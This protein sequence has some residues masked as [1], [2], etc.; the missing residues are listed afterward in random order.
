[1]E[2]HRTN[3]VLHGEQIDFLNELAY[4]YRK[5]TGKKITTSALMRSMI[6]YLSGLEEGY[7]FAVIQSNLEQGHEYEN[8]L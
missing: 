7:Q 6:R 5:T 4:R 2:T 8:N 1:M 3:I